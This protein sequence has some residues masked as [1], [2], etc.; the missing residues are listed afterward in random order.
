MS[1]IFGKVLGKGS[2]L[3][4]IFRVRGFGMA[5]KVLQLSGCLKKVL[6]EILIESF[7]LSIT[8]VSHFFFFDNE[9]KIFMQ[10]VCHMK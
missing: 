7:S 10:M 9:P 1:Y 8:N 4:L 3:G 5:F 2:S 6:G